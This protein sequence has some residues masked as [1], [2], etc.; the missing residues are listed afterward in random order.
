[1]N[2]FLQSMNHDHF[3]NEL[4]TAVK[5][6]GELANQLN[7]Q[8]D[9]KS[10]EWG[11]NLDKV[12]SEIV[13]VISAIR[14]DQRNAVNAELLNNFQQLLSKYYKSFRIV[15]FGNRYIMIESEHN[16]YKPIEVSIDMLVN[17]ATAKEVDRIKKLREQKRILDWRV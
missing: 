8:K 15:S 13:D 16:S 5:S 10:V 12:W 6:I 7:L 4:A 14:K 11:A 3:I 1:M 17:T 2:T 9:A